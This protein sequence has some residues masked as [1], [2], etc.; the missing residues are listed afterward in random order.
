MQMYSVNTRHKN[1]LHKPTANLS[2][3]QKSMHYAGIKIFN[4]LPSDLKSLTNEKAWFQVALK[5]H[6]NTYSFYSFDEYLLSKKW[7]IHV[8]VV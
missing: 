7:L 1:Y 2:C 3:F 6:L 4:T 5:W 8:K